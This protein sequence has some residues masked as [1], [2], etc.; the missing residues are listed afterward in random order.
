MKNVFFSE[1]LDVTGHKCPVPVLRVRRMLERMPVGGTLKVLATD[2]MTLID[3][4][5]FCQ[6]NNY[7][8]L[9]MTEDEDILY[10]L[11]NK[12]GEWSDMGLSIKKIDE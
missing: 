8:I 12:T 11:I 4:P 6:E 5:H 9:K 7:N 2:P 1:Q 3:I 10:F